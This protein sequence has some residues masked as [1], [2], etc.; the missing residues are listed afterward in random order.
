MYISMAHLLFKTMDYRSLVKG[1]MK[2]VFSVLRINLECLLRN[3][4]LTLLLATFSL[5]LWAEEESIL[6]TDVEVSQKE[7]QKAFFESQIEIYTQTVGEE[8]KGLAQIQLEL[9]ILNGRH[10]AELHGR[11][12]G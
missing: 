10:I 5:P 8:Y 11:A 7:A 4:G 9:S 2:I 1:R 3:L 12:R 6:K